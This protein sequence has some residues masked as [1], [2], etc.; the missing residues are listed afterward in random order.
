MA[1]QDQVTNAVRKLME[2]AVLLRSI[3]KK[4]LH[5]Q[6]K[7]DG[8]TIMPNKMN[9]EEYSLWM[10]LGMEVNKEMSEEEEDT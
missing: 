1:T 2:E 9:F 7:H 6:F 3:L 8:H 4:T 10:D 5:D